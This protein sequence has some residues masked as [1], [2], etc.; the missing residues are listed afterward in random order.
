MKQTELFAMTLDEYQEKALATRLPSANEEYV[1]LGLVG[2]VGEIFSLVAKTIRDGTPTNYH[3]MM[4]KELGDVLWFIAALANDH[5]YGLEEI[6]EGNINKLQ[7]RK[8]SKTLQGS[9][10]DR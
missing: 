6:A 9:G 3:E 7:Q 8:T 1:L 4:K 5:G 2:E 10:D